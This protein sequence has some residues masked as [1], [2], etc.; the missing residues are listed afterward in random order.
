MKSNKY[1]IIFTLTMSRTSSLI[2][3]FLISLIV[4]SHAQPSE[5]EITF[6]PG[7]EGTISFKQY[8]GYIEIADPVVENS[9]CVCVCI[10]IP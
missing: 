4:C 8:S 10:N 9:R 5:D 2:L 1:K 3:F 6:L 7:V